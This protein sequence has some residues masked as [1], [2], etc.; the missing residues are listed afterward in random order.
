MQKEREFH[1]A[2]NK[3]AITKL[4]SLRRYLSFSVE[5]IEI[6]SHVIQCVL[7][8]VIIRQIMKTATDCFFFLKIMLDYISHRLIY[9]EI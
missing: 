5:L 3:V 8:L 7:S 2:I 4:N 9:A 6:H 1:S